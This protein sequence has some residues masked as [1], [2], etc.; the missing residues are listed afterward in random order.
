MW[1]FFSLPFSESEDSLIE[2]NIIIK[3]KKRT[4]DKTCIFFLFFKYE[5]RISGVR[6]FFFLV[7]E[8]RIS[9]MT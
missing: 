6:I 8:K 7:I 3:N 5:N 2:N 9:D 4:P 1:I